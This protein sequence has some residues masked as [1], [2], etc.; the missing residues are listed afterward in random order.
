VRQIRGNVQGTHGGQ[1]VVH[2]RTFFGQPGG[3][4]EARHFWTDSRLVRLAGPAAGSIAVWN[5]SPANRGFG[6]VGIVETVSGNNIRFAD[7]NRQPAN[8]ERIDIRNTRP[9]AKLHFAS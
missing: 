2:V 4:L 3:I 7:S 9:L 8:A 5:G 1:C 6:H